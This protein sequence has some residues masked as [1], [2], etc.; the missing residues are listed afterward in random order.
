M[1]GRALETTLASAM[2]MSSYYKRQEKNI[3]TLKKSS[4]SFPST[5][6]LGKG[7]ADAPA[8]RWFSWNNLLVSTPSATSSAGGG[9]W[10]RDEGHQ[11]PSCTSALHIPW[12]AHGMMWVFPGMKHQLCP[13]IPPQARP[14][15]TPQ[16]RKLWVQHTHP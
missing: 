10:R 6:P 15:L 1:Q 8:H 13:Q 3:Y 12:D 11:P 5:R 2:K 14:H 7:N 9:F 4:T 16:G